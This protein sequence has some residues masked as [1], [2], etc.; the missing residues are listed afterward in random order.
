MQAETKD[1]SGVLGLPAIGVG[2]GLLELDGRAQR[3]GRTGKFGPRPVICRL[4][5]A[6]AVAR[7]GGL[8][9]LDAVLHQP[10]R[11]ESFM[12]SRQAGRTD[13]VCVKNYRHAARRSGHRTL[14]ELRP[15][16]AA[17]PI[18]RV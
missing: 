13:H 16:I 11:P 15:H 3:L 8:E 17:R 18:Q 10:R 2:H 4:D 12:L 7:H 5:Q 1:D 9:A 14:L 6:S